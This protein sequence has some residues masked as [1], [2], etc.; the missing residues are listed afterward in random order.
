MPDEKLTD[1]IVMTIAPKP[2]NSAENPE[3]SGLIRRF[4]ARAYSRAALHYLAA[5]LLLIVAIVFGR[6]R[7]TDRSSTRSGDYWRTRGVC[8]HDGSRVENGP[9]GR[10]AGRG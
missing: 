1:S 2:N 10:H 5:G 9:Q 4:L 7:Y 8:S 3:A 6:Q